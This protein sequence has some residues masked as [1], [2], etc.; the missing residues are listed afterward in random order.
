LTGEE[1]RT[2]VRLNQAEAE[3]YARLRTIYT[4]IARHPWETLPANIPASVN[5]WDLGRLTAAEVE[6]MVQEWD[7]DK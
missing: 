7:N 5:P 6:Q 3:R 4:R 2:T 1:L